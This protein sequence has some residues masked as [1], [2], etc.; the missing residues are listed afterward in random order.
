LGIGISLELGA[1]N[2][3]FPRRYSHSVNNFFH[4]CLLRIR[5]PWFYSQSIDRKDVSMSSEDFR[6]LARLR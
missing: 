4:V 1:W 6:F 5:T 2:L 3:E